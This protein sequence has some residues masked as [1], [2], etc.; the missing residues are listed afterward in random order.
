MRVSYL[1]VLL[2]IILPILLFFIFR[3]AVTNDEGYILHSSERMI[4]GQ[5]P[6]R[7]FHFVY[8]PLSLFLTEGIF[9]IFG[10]SIFSSRILIFATYFISSLLIYKVVQLATKNKLYS[11]LAMFIFISWGPTHIN[12]SWPVVFAIF[13]GLFSCYFLM[14]FIDTR[15]DLYLFVA[16]LSCF[17]VFLSK[18]NFGA[19]IGLVALTFFS[20]RHARKLSHILSFLYGFS[21]GLIFFAIYLLNTKSVP[22]FISDF[23]L[24]TIK[25]IVIN[26]GLTTSFIYPDTPTN[27]LARTLLYLTPLILSVLALVLV[28]KRRRFHLIFLPVFVLSFYLVGIRPTTDY[29]H[30]VPLLS[31]IGIPIALI[32]RYNIVS[33]VRAVLLIF[34]AGMI[35]LGFQTGLFKGYYRWDS[36]LITN[37]IYSSNPRVGVY[38]NEKLDSTFKQFVALTNKYTMP[39]DYILVNSYNPMI[40]FVTDRREATKHNFISTGVVPNDYYKEV[41]GT[42]V[43]KKLKLIILEK[44]TLKYLPIRDYI[45]LHYRFEETVGDYDTYVLRP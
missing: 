34:S 7:D 8:T 16:G 38:L 30:L 24:F 1:S 42:L 26:S 27:M 18:Q 29:I 3:G 45:F 13:S 43:A 17:L 36:P 40:Y 25:R 21:W 10:E 2:L 31:L 22:A 5:M 33:T 35:I 32:L 14:K 9:R 39:H 37:T 44:S 11:T 15:H 6:Y 12:F 23:Y 19:S 4:Q 41:L 20:I 28:T